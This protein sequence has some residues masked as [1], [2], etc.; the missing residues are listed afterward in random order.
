MPARRFKILDA[1]IELRGPAASVEP[2]ACAYRRFALVDPVLVGAGTAAVPDDSPSVNG[3]QILPIEG[4]DPAL[5][6]YGEFLLETR[7]LITSTALIHGASLVD[8]SGG[9][10]LI[11]APSSF[12]KTSLAL[13]LLARGHRLLSDDYS[14]LDLSTGC[15]HP[16]PRAVAVDPGGSA[17]LP[18]AFRDAAARPNAPRLL[19]KALLDIGEVLGEG[20]LQREPTPLRRVVLLT[21]DTAFSL[22]CDTQV[23]LRVGALAEHSRRFERALEGIS[24]VAVVDR[25]ERG[26]MRFWTLVLDTSRRPS[27]PLSRLFDDP[28]VVFV[29]R[30]GESTPT[31]EG[32]P[33]SRPIPR[34]EAALLLAREMLNRREG[35][36]ALAAYGG[37]LAPLLLDLAGALRDAGCFSVKPGR[38]L[39]RTAAM[40]ENL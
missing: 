14:P 6:L 15:V 24:G 20:A 3:R 8:S 35:G 37:R 23:E 11:A 2:I 26:A 34:S 10:T 7:R 32:S 38:D 9:A 5:Q 21:G 39:D 27:E 19:G 29:E 13:G 18:A 22:D 31:F 17:P 40:T 4:Y 1:T 16:F 33:E 25:G 36:G 30:W 28:A 12:G